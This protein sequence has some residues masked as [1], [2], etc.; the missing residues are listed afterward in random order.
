[1]YNPPETLSTTPVIYDAP[2]PR[3][4]CDGFRN[5]LRVAEPPNRETLDQRF[6]LLVGQGVGHGCLNVTRGDR[7][8]GDAA[9]AESRAR[10]L[11]KPMT[12]ALEA[13]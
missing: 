3:E 13:A 5:I 1:M 7:V 11:V 6:A 2:G 12:P 4:E 8:D 9:G 10:L